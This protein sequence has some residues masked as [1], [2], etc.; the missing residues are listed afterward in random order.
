M[1]CIAR[2]EN[3]VYLDKSNILIRGFA[4]IRGKEFNS[5]VKKYFIVKN[6]NNEVVYEKKLNLQLR[7]DITFLYRKDNVN[8]NLSG[9]QEFKVDLNELVD[10][11]G[12][13][14]GYIRIEDGNIHDIPIEI[15]LA[16]IKNKF[17][18]TCNK[19]KR[20][21]IEWSF[22]EKKYLILKIKEKPKK[23]FIIE[24][25]RNIKKNFRKIKVL[26]KNHNYKE[27]YILFL[28]FILRIIKYKKDIWLIGERKDTAQDNSYV[29]FKYLKENKKEVNSYYIIDK[30]SNDYK[31]IS[32]YNKVL[33]WGSIRHTLY[34]LIARFSINSYSEKANMYTEE[35]KNILKLFP[36]ITNRKKVFLQHGVIGL[37]RLNHSL[38]KNRAD[39]DLFFVSSDFEKSHIVNEYGYGEEE[40]KV[41]GL[42]RWDNLFQGDYIKN[43]TILIMPTWRNWL[44]NEEDLLKSQY[45]NKYIELLQNEK[46]LKIVKENRYN[47]KVYFHYHIEK[48][49]RNIDFKLSDEIQIVYRNEEDIQELIKSSDI[50]IS[51][52]SSVIF[53]FAFMKKPVLLYQFD[54]DLFFNN[55]YNEGPIENK[56]FF[57]FIGKTQ[58]EIL[59][60]LEKVCKYEFSYENYTNKINKFINNIDDH[61]CQRTFD[62][63]IN[64]GIEGSRYE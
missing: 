2:I 43:N 41:S 32:N 13:Y 29:F 54:Y 59:K 4:F 19:Q 45:F 3:I 53:D 38:H 30:S 24:N 22:E 49:I 44:K 25:L 33:N 55:H 52:Y 8:Y 63:I 47:V 12:D 39:L 61:N 37:S 64:L 26:I 48:L 14:K 46:F 57:P 15:K 50:F 40:V 11:E 60:K 1:N 58:D 36:N 28:Y 10:L 51:D 62:S 23:Y 7:T 18:R 20:K 31:K 5:K 27:V 16:E 6:K 56:D 34:L 21:I 42:C 9:F 35:Y 17:I